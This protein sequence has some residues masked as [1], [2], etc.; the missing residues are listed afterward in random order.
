MSSMECEP[1]EWENKTSLSLPN[2]HT[3]TH[4][5]THSSFSLLCNTLMQ[6]RTLSA[7]ATR[8]KKTSFFTQSAALTFTLDANQ[9]VTQSHRIQSIEHNSSLVSDAEQ[10]WNCV[11]TNISG[12][13]QLN[14]HSC[15]EY[16]TPNTVYI[17][18]TFYC[19][20]Y[21]FLYI[22]QTI[23]FR[24]SRRFWGYLLYCVPPEVQN[25]EEKKQKIFFKFLKLFLP[26]SDLRENIAI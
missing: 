24:V 1:L 14:E 21:L 6:T 11:R 26:W 17:N 10:Q 22:I 12:V 7:T 20:F 16:P 25:N 2:T 4:K 15:W 18:T 9:C 13:F 5:H 19:Y 3:N 23:L 8:E